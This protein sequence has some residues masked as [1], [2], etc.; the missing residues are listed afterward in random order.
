MAVT[1]PE[2]RAVFQFERVVVLLV[3]VDAFAEFADCSYGVPCETPVFVSVAVRTG[4][5]VALRELF[6]LPLVG[7]KQDRDGF[8]DEPERLIA[9][10]RPRLRE[11]S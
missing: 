5:T 2:L 10:A 11:G 7:R 6:D 8:A 4:K 9:V 3:L 1:E